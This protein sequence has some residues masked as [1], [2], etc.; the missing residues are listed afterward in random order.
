[1]SWSVSEVIGALAAKA[2][3]PSISSETLIDMK[4]YDSRT[5]IGIGVDG[6]DQRILVLPGQE[7]V[8]SFSTKNADFDPVCAVSWLEM[9]VS[10]PKT[11]TL[12]CRSDFSIPDVV[13]AV[14][15]I[16][17]G[18]IELQEKFGTSGRAIWQMKQLFENGFQA[19]FSDETLLGLIG[20][21]LIIDEVE[22]PES[23]IRFWHTN[24]SDTFD[25]SSENFRLEV[26][27]SRS[28]TRNHNFS[29]NQ[30]GTNLDA[31]LMIASI[32]L[33]TVEVGLT[34]KELIDQICLKLDSLV[35]QILVERVLDILGCTP[36]FGDHLNFDQ[37]SSISS[38]I[39]VEG[40][41]VPRPTAESGVISMSWLASLS[42]A[43]TKSMNLNDVT[44]M[45]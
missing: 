3:R 16:F 10:L 25:F 20:E 1:M 5:G 27:T 7:D 33:Q 12:T 22:N 43:E 19:T 2:N 36:E 23:F 41:A 11:A 40:V 30:I 14:A 9:E 29:S 13:E 26:K 18:L 39:F 24:P 28:I 44:K 21:L 38:I 15:V 17:L 37:A 45:L 8:T 35:A 6:L 32:I 42:D 34:L 4:L 31:K